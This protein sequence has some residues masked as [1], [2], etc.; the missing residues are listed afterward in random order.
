MRIPNI[1]ADFSHQQRLKNVMMV[2]IISREPKNEREIKCFLWQGMQ[3]GEVEVQERAS[4]YLVKSITAKNLSEKRFLGYRGNILRGG[5]QN[6]HLQHSFILGAGTTDL[7]VQCIQEGRWNPNREQKFHTKG[8]E[9]TLSAMRFQNNSQRKI[10]ETIYRTT[11]NTGTISPTQDFT[12][13]QDALLSNNTTSNL[14]NEVTSDIKSLLNKIPAPLENQVGIV[15]VLPPSKDGDYHSYHLEL[16]YSPQLYRLVHKDLLSSFVIDS[17]SLN[18]AALPKF[19]ETEFQQMLS[20]IVEAE[21]H[22]FTPVGEEICWRL[23]LSSMAFG[24][25]VFD[26]ET[27]VHLMYASSNLGIPRRR[28]VGNYQLME[29]IGHGEMGTVFLAYPNA[30]E[31]KRV[32]VKILN[33]QHSRGSEL[34]KRF[35]REGEVQQQMRHQNVVQTLEVGYCERVKRLYI[36]MEYAEGKN[37]EMIVTQE[38]PMRSPTVMKIAQK[39]ASALEYARK[40]NIIHRDIKP[41]NIIFRKFGNVC[42]LLD[43]GLGKFM[44]GQ[45]NTQLTVMGTVMGT[46]YYSS[47]QQLTDSSTTDHRD[48]IYSLGATLYHLLAGNPPYHE[49][50]GFAQ[51]CETILDG[52]L[53]PLGSINR[54]LPKE[55]VAIV[56]KSMARERENR[57][58]TAGEMLKAIEYAYDSWAIPPL[59]KGQRVDEAYAGYNLLSLWGDND[60]EQTYLV[61]HLDSKQYSVMKR[62]KDESISAEKKAAF[63]EMVKNANSKNGGLLPIYDYGNKDGYLFVTLKYCCMGS[64]QEL[65]CKIKGAKLAVRTTLRLMNIINKDIRFLKNQGFFVEYINPWTIYMERKNSN[66]YVR[67]TGL[68]NFREM[69]LEYTRYLSPEQV[70]GEFQKEKSSVYSVA[71]IMYRLLSGK[72]PFPQK[73]IVDTMSAIVNGDFVPLSKAAPKLHSEVAEIITKA[74]SLEYKDR[75]KMREFIN[76]IERVYPNY[77]VD[78]K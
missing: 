60:N 49:C 9:T 56:E 8:A 5:G 14:D 65:F 4:G 2:P 54:D 74:M 15:V 28:V 59:D 13:L 43:F 69:N 41:G 39:M 47:P 30:D 12:V 63:T 32:V 53:T 58:Q 7:P 3:D 37:L 44:G 11:H 22:F 21:W 51:L 50:K 35:L 45:H 72:P 1:Y 61:Q 78:E 23:P 57:Y 10:W 31:E 19:T 6:R 64:L 42:R 29:K 73:D 76:E 75:P 27:I 71:A 25:A 24:E 36:V 68:E 40:K 38:G 62:V 26:E 16:H 17:G 20:S 18:T 33:K 34:Y 55:L 70:K 46:P 48:D 52:A 77:D 67:F 66:L